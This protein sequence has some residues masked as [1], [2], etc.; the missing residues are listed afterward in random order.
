LT[1]GGTQETIVEP[2]SGFS[3][4]FRQYY[5]WQEGKMHLNMGFIQGVSVGNSAGLQRILING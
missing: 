1:G 5:N 4:S 3:L 2:D